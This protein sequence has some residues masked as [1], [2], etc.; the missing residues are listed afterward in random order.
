MNMSQ[1][2]RQMTKQWAI[3]FGQLTLLHLLLFLGW[4]ILE[5]VAIRATAL[6][7]LLIIVYLVLSAAILVIF[8]RRLGQA[9]TAKVLEIERTHWRVRRT[10]NFRFQP[11]PAKREYQ[12]RL[13]VTRPGEPDYEAWLAEFLPGGQVPKKG[14]VIP[15]KVHP[16]R[17]DIIVMARDKPS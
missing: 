9:A 4:I 1:R 5:P 15:I 13:R 2:A 12:M 7:A 3:L 11:R 16:Q 10:R 8:Y 14:D 6:I 17:P